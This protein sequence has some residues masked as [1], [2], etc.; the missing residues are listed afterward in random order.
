MFLGLVL[1]SA[2]Q[3]DKQFALEWRPLLVP[4]A[5][6]NFI[7]K[8]NS[9]VQDVMDEMDPKQQVEEQYKSVN[10][11]SFQWRASRLLLSQSASYFQVPSKKSEVTA[12][13]APFLEEVI[14]HT[15][16]NI[17]VSDRLCIYPLLASCETPTYF[18]IIS[19][20]SFY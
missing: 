17:P 4:F 6:R 14:R 5:F 19:L 1:R 8:M 2:L 15:A 13:M 16:A 7:P 9:V 10:N 11:E 12:S 18:S 20:N 3:N